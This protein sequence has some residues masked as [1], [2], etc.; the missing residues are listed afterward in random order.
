M[1]SFRITFTL[2]ALVHEINS[3]ADGI[4]R[5]QFGITY[6]QFLFLVT[7]QSSGETSPSTLANRLGVTR[8]AVSQR[9]EWFESRGLV[10]ITNAQQQG[11]QLLLNLTAE[12]T[13][14][15]NSS[16]EF[17]ETAFR[18]VFESFAEVDLERLNSQLET[19]KLHFVSA[20]KGEE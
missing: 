12:G 7:L 6:S 1:S 8:S 5:D 18:G 17:L 19:V 10:R 16:S 20:T 15:A 2:N 13:E 3:S 11:N 14:L 4:L 9:M